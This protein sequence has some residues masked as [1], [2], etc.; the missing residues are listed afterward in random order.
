MSTRLISHTPLRQSLAV[1][2]TDLESAS[3]GLP[4]DYSYLKNLV[5]SFPGILDLPAIGRAEKYFNLPLGTCFKATSRESGLQMRRL[6]AHALRE[7]GI[8]AIE[9]G[10][11]DS[12][13]QFTLDLVEAMGCT[14]DT[15]SSTQG[16]LWDVT[17]KPEG[18]VSAKSGDKAHSKSHGVGEFAWHTDGAFEENPQ[19]FF[20]LHIVHPDKLGGG[21]FRVLPAGDLVAS[22]KPSS[23]E[24]LLNTEFDLQVPDEFYKG[25][26]TI[27]GKLLSIDPNT[28]HY[29]LRYRRDILADPPS[30][31]PAANEAVHELNDLLDDPSKAGWRL[32]EDVFKENV[33]L[34]MDNTKFLHMRTEIHDKR[35]HLRRV[36]FHGMPKTD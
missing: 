15:H 3:A 21:I 36:R 25:K 5:K 19:R 18:V 23:V 12:A 29:M 1:G 10:F 26:A 7:H 6:F 28:G 31:D 13:S 9:L 32:P 4:P 22:L 34:L 27:K 2:S 14:P 30:N 20:G 17:Y 8:V 35:R 11:E 16:A 24:T 33:V